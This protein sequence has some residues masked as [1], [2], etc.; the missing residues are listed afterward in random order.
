MRIGVVGEVPRNAKTF[1]VKNHWNLSQLKWWP[2]FDSSPLHQF[3]KFNLFLVLRWVLGK[4]LSN[5]I[6]PAWKLDNPY[7]HNTCWPYIQLTCY[8]ETYL[9]KPSLRACLNK[10]QRERAKPEKRFSTCVNIMGMVSLVNVIQINQINL[11]VL[12]KR[13]LWNSP[14]VHGRWG[15]D[16]KYFINECN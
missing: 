11:F 9:A 16:L 15:S 7:F 12:K 1:Y 14:W 8:R 2:I 3:S 13:E 6:S 4:N 5:F 10:V